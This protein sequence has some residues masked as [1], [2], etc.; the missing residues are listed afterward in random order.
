MS[1]SLS[2]SL[3]VTFFNRNLGSY[4][5][6][7]TSYGFVSPKLEDHPLSAVYC[8]LYIFLPCMKKGVGLND[9]Y[10][11]P[12]CRCL[13]ATV[14]RRDAE[15]TNLVTIIC[16]FIY[17]SPHITVASRLAMG[18]TQSSVKRVT[19]GPFPGGVRR[20]LYSS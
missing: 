17:Q 11:N 15:L 2:C 14:R 12:S 20:L 10:D 8:C 6:F 13:T 5:N 16:F 18:P 7:V 1:R 19:G 9:A 4:D 3:S